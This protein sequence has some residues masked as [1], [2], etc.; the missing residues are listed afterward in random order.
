MHRM[1]AAVPDPAFSLIPFPE[2]KIDGLFPGLLAKDALLWLSPWLPSKPVAMVRPGDVTWGWLMPS[3]CM[4]FAPEV[5]EL[6]VTKTYPWSMSTHYYCHALGVYQTLP[7]ILPTASHSYIHS[8]RKH[9]LRSYC[10]DQKHMVTTR[11]LER[12]VLWGR[13]Y[14]VHFTDGTTEAS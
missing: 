1:A 9:L 6:G 13:Y 12:N 7:N 2:G 8:F 3:I 11:T 5:R 4:C 10:D 14:H